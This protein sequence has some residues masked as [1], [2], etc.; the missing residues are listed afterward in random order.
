MSHRI[1][2]SLVNE[3]NEYQRFVKF[4]A[5]AAARRL[6]V[7]LETLSANSDA[8]AQARQLS[9]LLRRD[10]AVRPQGVIVFP[11]RDASLSRVGQDVVHAGLGWVLLNRRAPWVEELQ[12]TARRVPVGLVGPDQLENGRLQGRQVRALLPSG[13]HILCVTGPTPSSAAQDRL[14][15]LQEALEGSGIETSQVAGNWDAAAAEEAVGAWLRVVLYTRLQ[16]GAVACQ[17]DA[18]AIGARQVLDR[19]AAEGHPALAQVPVLGIDGRDSVGKK[20]VHEGRL[21]ATIIQPSSGAP[22]VEWMARALSGERVP[23]RVVLAVHSYPD[24]SA[25]GPVQRAS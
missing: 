12:Q 20:L 18:M 4:D 2:L 13:G 23:P 1:V 14:R 9:E 17:N 7:D 25:L 3:S 15:G 21:A 11:V 10:P 8:A 19:L 24:V 22:A 16:L 5:E 6:N